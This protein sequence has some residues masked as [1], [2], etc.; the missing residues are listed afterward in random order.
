MNPLS[1]MWGKRM[2]ILIINK[3][4]HPNG[5]S[6][7]YVFKI[8]EQ[9]IKM[10]H[11][12]QYFGM[13][14]VGRIVGNRIDSYTSDMD[15]HTRKADKLLYPLKIIYSSEARRKL[16]SVLEDFSPDVVH[17]NNF[18]FQLTPSIIYEVRDYERKYHKKIKIVYT[19]HDY[20]LICPNHLLLRPL[21]NE[22][23]ERC[24]QRNPFECTKGRCIHGSR[25]KSFL[26]SIEGWIYRK[27]HVYRKIDKI[28]CPSNFMEK[29]LSETADLRGKL[30]TMHNFV[31][32]QETNK[33]G[34]EEYV[35][36]FGRYSRE[37]GV[38]TLL[39]VC[40]EIPDIPFVFAGGGPLEKEVSGIDNI[41]NRGF[42]TGESLYKT[43]S[44]A[45]FTI[46]PSEWYENCPF[47]VMETQMYGTPVL[48]ADM[49]GTKELV[50]DGT[51]G[52]MFQAGNKEQLK[53]K[54]I[55]L[56]NDEELLKKYTEGCMR[57]EFDSAEEYCEKL[58]GVYGDD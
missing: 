11:E 16:R 25:V 57:V 8:G 20:Q 22:V 6:E 19:A 37:K 45:A 9:L 26:G 4:L 46:F 55:K 54:I 36:Y 43:I 3:F 28:I 12:V 52:E 14:H 5:G 18:N 27:N 39:E 42:Q 34:K 56:W 30:L 38:A 44:Q 49:G 40:R 32:R 48:A 2:R 35:L 41:E 47:S 10:G 24:I 53:E 15:F 1:I 51:S 13:D 23:C 50:L 58:M 21:E 33:Y 31:D 17:L 29:K 7:T